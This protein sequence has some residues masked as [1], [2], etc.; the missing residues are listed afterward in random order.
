MAGEWRDYKTQGK[1]VADN[2]VRGKGWTMQDIGLATTSCL[3]Q[4]NVFWGKDGW[5]VPRPLLYL[6]VGEDRVIDP[7]TSLSCRLTSND[8]GVSNGN[9]RKHTTIK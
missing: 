7:T 8:K 4:W 6:K 9:Q 1:W 3:R 5:V 2:T